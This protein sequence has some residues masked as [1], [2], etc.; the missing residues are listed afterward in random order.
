MASEHESPE[1]L[2]ALAKTPYMRLTTFRRDGRGVATAV[3]VVCSGEQVFFRTWDVS[4]KAKR[5][6]HTPRVEVAPCTIRGRPVGAPI[7]AE[8]RLLVGAES[9]HAAA[10]LS[11]RHPILHGHLIPWYHRRRGWTTQQYRVVQRPS[12][13]C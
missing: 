9:D 6:R 5:L 7:E 13:G 8:A 2:A 12:P 3:H 11:S 1:Q 10:L 4:G